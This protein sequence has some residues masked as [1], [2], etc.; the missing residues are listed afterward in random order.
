MPDADPA[1]TIPAP[2]IRAPHE[3]NVLNPLRAVP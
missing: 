3:C 1:Q 2:A